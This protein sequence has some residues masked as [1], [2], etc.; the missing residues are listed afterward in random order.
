M[1]LLEYHIGIL[2]DAIETGHIQRDNP[3]IIEY[4]KRLIDEICEITEEP[5]PET[6]IALKVHKLFTDYLGFEF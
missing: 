5:H 6:R 4:Q 1:K 3:I 2:K